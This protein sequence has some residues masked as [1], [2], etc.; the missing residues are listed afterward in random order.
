LE[1]QAPGHGVVV[2]HRVG[3]QGDRDDGHHRQSAQT[4]PIRWR[5]W[6][7]RRSRGW[8]TGR[9]IRGW[10]AGRWVRWGQERSDARG[11]R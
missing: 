10:S 5:P 6:V 2:A 8:S 3:R 11:G 1:N 7:R 4:L 9:R